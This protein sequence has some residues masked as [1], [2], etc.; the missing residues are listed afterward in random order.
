MRNM[1]NE[2]YP[3]DT[4]PIKNNVKVAIEQLLDALMIDWQNDPNTKNTPDRVAKMY[5]EEI[6]GGRFSP[7]PKATIFPNTRKV[8][9]LYTVGAIP[10][11][12]VCSHHLLPIEGHVWIGVIPQNRLL[13]LSKFARL[14]QWVFARPQ[15]QEEATDQ[16][17]EVIDKILEPKGLGVICKSNHA[18]MSLRGVKSHGTKMTT[19]VL[20]GLLQKQE[21]KSEFLE[22]VK[23]MEF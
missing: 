16:L 8:D 15:I 10:V 20:K 5:T 11:A 12:G 1:A 2:N 17:A 13:G 23:G 7:M 3:Q 22:F 14:A 18:C 19:S 4:A 9:E 21:A 6:L